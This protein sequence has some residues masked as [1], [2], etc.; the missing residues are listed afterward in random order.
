MFRPLAAAAL[1]ALSINVAKAETPTPVSIAVA[2]GD[3]N[4]SR[5]SDA[6]I[7]ADR[8]QAAAKAVCINENLGPQLRSGRGVFEDCM[9]VAING[10]IDH[11]E[12]SLDN[13]IH[14][15]IAGSIRRASANP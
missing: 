2:Y 10:A 3:L 9:T 8:L 6:K 11:I 7:L 4:L 14:G 1:F 13:K 5:S 12:A 15:Q